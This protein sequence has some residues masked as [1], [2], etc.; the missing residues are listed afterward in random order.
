M[1]GANRTNNIEGDTAS[2]RLRWERIKNNNENKQGD[3]N[4]NECKRND[5]NN[6]G[7]KQNNN[8]GE[9]NDKENNNEGE[10]TFVRLHAAIFDI[11]YL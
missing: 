7:Y 11:R 1:T 5:D 9:Q 10:Q 6:N 3:K 8:E 2:C 4:D